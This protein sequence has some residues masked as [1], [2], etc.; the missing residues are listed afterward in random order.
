MS[1][2]NISQIKLIKPYLASIS[3]VQYL[4][5]VERLL[6]RFVCEEKCRLCG[7]RL[8]HF[9]SNLSSARCEAALEDLKSANI[10]RTES[11]LS[12]ADT[13]CGPCWTELKSSGS[14]VRNCSLAAPLVVIAS[15]APYNAEMKKLI[16]RFKDQSD[17]LISCDLARLMARAALSLNCLFDESSASTLVPVPLHKWR[18]VKR[19]FNQSELLAKDVGKIIGLP[20]DSRALVRTRPTPCQKQLTKRERLLNLEGAFQGRPERL[21]GKT[22][23]VV[24]DVSTSGATLAECAK[25][26]LKC[27]ANRVLALTAARALLLLES[28]SLGR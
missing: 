26:V 14:L 1:D 18:Q 24:D 17:R 11:I 19:G 8:S 16:C 5:R 7:A 25:E 6:I 13:M 21:K 12:V 3:I 22:I 4:M 20:V 9:G 28:N 10:F 15:G 2:L 27:G 23:I